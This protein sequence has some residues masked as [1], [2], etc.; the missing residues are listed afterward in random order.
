MPKLLPEQLATLL[1]IQTEIYKQHPLMLPKDFSTEPLTFPKKI[2]EIIE[3]VISCAEKQEMFRIICAGPRGGGKTRGIAS[4]EI[5]LWHLYGW[6]VIN[7]GGSFTQAEKVYSYLFEAFQ[8]KSLAPFIERSVQRSTKSKQ[9]SQIFVLAATEKQTRSPHIGGKNKG[10]LL[11]IDEECEAEENV[12]NSALPTVNSAHPSGIIRS[13]TFHKAVGTFQKTWDTAEKIGYKKFKWNCFDVAEKCV[14]NCQDVV[15]KVSGI[16]GQCNVWEYCKGAAHDNAPAGSNEAGWIPIEEIRQSAREMSSDEFEV[17]LMGSRPSGTGL[18]FPPEALASCVKKETYDLKPAGNTSIGVDWGFE[19]ET[20]IVHIQE[21]TIDVNGKK[22]PKI[23]LI[24]YNSF[25]RPRDEEIFTEL[26][27]QSKEFQI[28]LYLDE[29][30]KFQN[31]HLA[32]M[33]AITYEVNFRTNKER[34][35]SYLKNLMEKGLL[36]IPDEYEHLIAQLTQYRRGKTGK[37]LKQNDHGVDA[38]ICAILHFTDE[39]IGYRT[40][41]ARFRVVDPYINRRR[42]RGGY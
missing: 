41:N 34:C 4:I 21:Q 39:G 2:R 33:G 42:G 17:E 3:H 19:G 6:D 24:Y 25:T 37:P 12:V 14:D 28:A 36:D 31:D 11:V 23:R 27:Y 30:H 38:L 29:S 13:S 9:G 15:D 22:V 40:D 10:G 16:S 5:I 8:S 26:R 32:N 35:I 7:L 18:L 20:A 1:A